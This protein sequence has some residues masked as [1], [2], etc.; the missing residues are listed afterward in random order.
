MRH[1][2]AA[3]L[4][5]DNVPL[6]AVRDLLGHTT[7]KMTERYAH[8]APENVRLAVTTLDTEEV[9]SHSGHSDREIGQGDSGRVATGDCSP[10]APTDPDVPDS[11]IRLLELWCRCATV[12]TVN[13]TRWGER[14]AL[15]QTDKLLPRHP[16]MPGATIEPLAPQPPNLVKKTGER[17]RVARDPIV[18]KVALELTTQR[19]AL[20]RHR[21]VSMRS[22][23]STDC[24]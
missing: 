13:Y 10:A 12:N 24:L 14:I 3:W 11:G 23:P 20:G 7:I 16:S 2:C 19:Q 21:P 9:R 1:T 4:V 22:A 15:G 8:L 18:G 6:T 17:S 5:S